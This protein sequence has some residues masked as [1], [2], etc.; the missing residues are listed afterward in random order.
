MEIKKGAH[1][2]HVNR[3]REPVNNMEMEKGSL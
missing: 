2:K 1:K 3:K